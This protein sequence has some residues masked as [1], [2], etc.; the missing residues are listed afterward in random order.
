MN[1][2]RAGIWVKS[3]TTPLL[4]KGD[5]GDTGNYHGI[6]LTVAAA[7]TYNKLLLDRIKS[8]LDPLLWINQNGFHSGRSTLVK[9]VTLRK[10]IEGVKAKEPL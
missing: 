5:V 10:L 1:G 2:D 9:I 3:G 8:G 4:K 7:K 6:S